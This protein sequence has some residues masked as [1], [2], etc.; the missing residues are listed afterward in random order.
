MTFKLKQNLLAAA[1][2]SCAATLIGCTAMSASKPADQA[3]TKSS[4]TIETKKTETVETGSDGKMQINKSETTADTTVPSAD[5]VGVL[6]CD[7]YIAKYESC[8][9]GKVP[10]SARGALQ[11]SIEQ[12]RKSWKQVAANPQTRATLASTCKQMQETSK[13]T[14]TAYGCDW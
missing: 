4:T 1:A 5:K 13:P 7:E 14:M 11:S 6:E 10:A 2:I 3:N 9:T 8:V 12:M